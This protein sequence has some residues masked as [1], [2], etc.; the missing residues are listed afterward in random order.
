MLSG[1]LETSTRPASPRLFPS[2]ACGSIRELLPQR[3]PTLP[4]KGE[5]MAVSE[6]ITNAFV[7]EETRALYAARVQV[8][9]ASALTLALLV[10]RT[11]SPPLEPPEHSVM[12]EH[13]GS[14][15]IVQ[16]A[17]LELCCM[18]QTCCMG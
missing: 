7:R 15:A 14:V 3:E 16:P 9:T 12:C 17:Q 2:V 8:A 18:A 4:P 1:N 10:A 13:K 6:E 11:L 5:A